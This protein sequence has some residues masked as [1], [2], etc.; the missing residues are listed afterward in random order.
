[1]RKNI[2]TIAALGV[3]LLVAPTATFADENCVDLIAADGTNGQNTDAG[4][5]CIKI[6]DGNLSVEYTTIGDWE[7]DQYHL[8]IGEDLAD[9]PQNKFGSPKLGKFPYKEI[10]LSGGDPVTKLTFSF[11]P[12]EFGFSE[13]CD[14]SEAT[15]VAHAVVARDSDFDGILDTFPTGFGDGFDLGGN[16]WA[17][18]MNVPLCYEYSFDASG[19][20]A[21]LADIVAGG[22]YEGVVEIQVTHNGG[23]S[24]AAYFT[25]QI[26]FDGDHVG[27]LTGLD[28]YCVDLANTIGGGWYC[29]LMVSSYNPN[30]GDL[31]GIV[32]EQN[33]DLANYVLNNY[34]IGDDLGLGALVTGGDIQRTI[35]TLVFGERPNAWQYASG[36]SSDA[37]VDAMLLAAYG[38]GESYQPSCDGKVAVVLY[39]VACTPEG[40]VAQALIAQAL[41]TDFEAACS[42]VCTTC[43]E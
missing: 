25:G 36:P 31:A 40:I 32:N 20:D 2:F 8:W 12:E 27:E 4:N 16:S 28:T 30:V 15:V 5:V 10:N 11:T 26:D 38:N 43:C 35:W 39:P 37:N 7:F 34:S 17:L 3:L 21:E 23:N 18:G 33:L 41:V 6:V 19:L 9:M 22:P 42:G 29:A 24:G 1:M 14:L 13:W